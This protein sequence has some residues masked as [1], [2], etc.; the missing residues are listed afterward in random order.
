[1]AYKQLG[2]G[3]S[4]NPQAVVPGAGAYT[5]EDHSW[6]GIV[7]Q[8][9]KPVLDWELNLQNE[10]C[11]PYGLE[12]HIRQTLASGFLSGDFFESGSIGSS[13]QFLAPIV[14]NE[15]SFV[16]NAAD[17]VINGWAVRFEYSDTSLVGQNQIYLPVPPVVGT[18]THVV[19][20]EAWRALVSATTLTNK[21]PSGQILRHGNAKAPDV[22]G[23]QNLVDDLIDPTYASETQAR[24]QVQYRYR[25]IPTWALDTYPEV[26]DGAVANTVPYLFASGVDGAATAY[27]YVRV[28]GDPGLW[29]AGTGDAISA[30]ALGTVDGYIY[31]IPLCAVC[32]RNSTAF[33]R[34]ANL[35]GG[36]AISMLTSDR[37]D[38]L[39]S[40]QIV[41]ADIVDLRKGASSNFQ[42]T[43]TRNFSNLL[44]NELATRAETTPDFCSGTSV[45]VRDEIGAGNLQPDAVR[46]HFSD[47][48]TTETITCVMSVA[49]PCASC[50]FDLTALP[51]AS[52]GVVNVAALVP[53]GTAIVGVRNVRMNVSD[54]GPPPLP[55]EVDGF[56][57]LNGVG[58]VAFITNTGSVVTLF[59][60]WTVPPVN[61][62][63][64]TVELEIAYPA[65]C[66][67]SRTPTS[68]AAV[69]MPVAAAAFVDPAYVT[70]LPD[71]T[72]LLLDN[73]ISPPLWSVDNAHRE[74][75]LTLKT[76]MLFGVANASQ[77]GLYIWLPYRLDGTPILITDGVN[78]PYLTTNYVL[79]VAYTKVTLSFPITPYTA[80]NVSYNMVTPAPP[81][82]F[83]EVFY[84]S[85][86]NQ[87]I[88]VPAGVY[89]MQLRLRAAPSAIT[90][91]TLG[92]ASPDDPLWPATGV[93]QIPL[94][95][96][97]GE[98]LVNSPVAVQVPN[99]SSLDSGMADVSVK[100][101]YL[102]NNEVI[103]RNNG[104][105][106]VDADGRN[107]WPRA[108]PEAT[109]YGSLDMTSDTPR[110]TMFPALMEVV[111]T[112]TDVVRPGTLVLAV[113]TDFRSLSNSV[114]SV[115]TIPSDGC[116]ALYRVRGN[117][118]NPRR[119]TP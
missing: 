11:G 66:G 111:S 58:F 119:L 86:A 118:M 38:G 97:G 40:D 99:S 71:V 8:Y 41:A 95:N 47:R 59:F 61:P 108:D 69:W 15:N 68:A 89:Q 12:Q 46:L 24:V 76:S 85:R 42:E 88:Q 104:D 48:A 56:D 114:V 72:R 115:V 20:I 60:A 9:N 43:L 67:L 35:N 73:S 91:D 2:P 31:A 53:P 75:R 77:D 5:A 107:F 1:M 17:L 21:S 27:A 65:G 55:A 19:I 100:F 7:F 52:Y 112:D 106:V 54:L 110:R 49:A 64:V 4:Q 116:A 62:V 80:V 101:A 83:Y 37:P 98:D 81:I 30:A 78:P 25:V 94:S 36:A 93:C 87:S 82:P 102:A 45:F 90:I 23:N 109:F 51:I 84:Y 79:D 34:T 44:R 18:D 22:V 96:G 105:T 29:R 92:S 28:D 10:V 103:L 63:S 50:A 117:L 32:R 3:V 74:L 16:V 13:F 57:P 14:G 6:E 26:P 113:F 39:F 33:D 70:V